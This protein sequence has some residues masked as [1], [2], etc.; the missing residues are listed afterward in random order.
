MPFAWLH[1]CSSRSGD[2]IYR[3]CRLLIYEG[4]PTL[5]TR[6]IIRQLSWKKIEKL[7]ADGLTA[8]EWLWYRTYVCMQKSLMTYDFLVVLGEVLKSTC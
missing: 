8:R 2:K 1:L 6:L 5:C 4:S 3:N 7:N